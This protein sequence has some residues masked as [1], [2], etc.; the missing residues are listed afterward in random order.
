MNKQKLPIL[1]G[2]CKIK[3]QKVLDA[4]VGDMLGDGSIN[5]GNYIKW[6]G[7]NGRLE[8]TF[9]ISN[10]AYLRH[11]KFNVYSSICTVQQKSQLLGLIFY[12]IRI[13]R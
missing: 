9:A 12:F 8:F 3:S 10:L 6:P 1:Q 11:L 7:T 2:I 13:K 4:I 5:R